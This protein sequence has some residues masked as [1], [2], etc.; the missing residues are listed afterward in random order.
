MEAAPAKCVTDSQIDEAGLVHLLVRDYQPVSHTIVL[1]AG[2]KRLPDSLH[3]PD[4]RGPNPD[5]NT[6]EGDI[7]SALYNR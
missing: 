4:G 3:H 6:A 7:I 2:F 1:S 5:N